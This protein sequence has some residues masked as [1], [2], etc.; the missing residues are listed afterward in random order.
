M[1]QYVFF[2]IVNNTTQYNSR[3]EHATFPALREYS[4]CHL[5]RV[6]SC[7][8]RTRKDAIREPVGNLV[9]IPSLN[10]CNWFVWL[11][12]ANLI[13]SSAK[14]RRIPQPQEPQDSDDQSANLSEQRFM[15]VIPRIPRQM[16]AC[17]FWISK[18]CLR[19]EHKCEAKGV[20]DLGNRSLTCAR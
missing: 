15:A 19:I 13:K 10:R 16:R 18:E 3:S 4:H 14:L 20:C 6:A 8:A 9:P 1:I 7:K 17:D 11:V 2:F 5:L 12:T